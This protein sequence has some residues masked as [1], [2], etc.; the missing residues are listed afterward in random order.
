MPSGQ[1]NPS[2]GQ[3]QNLSDDFDCYKNREVTISG[4]KITGVLSS[5]DPT[6]F[7]NHIP[8]VH[9]FDSPFAQLFPYADT[10]N[11]G[12]VYIA[13]LCYVGPAGTTTLANP[14]NVDPSTCKYDQFKVDA[15][16]PDT[17]KPTCRLVTIANGP[18][19]VL[20]V[21]VQDGP[22]GLLSVEYTSTN[23]TVTW[24]ANLVVGQTSPT[25][26]MRRRSIRRRE[27]P[28]PEGD[29]RLGQ[30]DDLR[31]GARRSRRAALA[32]GQ[33][34]AFVGVSGSQSG[35]SLKNL[36]G[37]AKTFVVTVNGHRIPRVTLSRG[38]ATTVSI[39]RWLHAKQ[40]NSVVVKA[41]GRGRSAAIIG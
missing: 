1:S 3:S 10:T 32:P 20:T 17:Q 19:K 30:R 5:S 26:S 9:Y 22:S 18:P 37:A 31:P 36:G 21:A 4:G 13:A 2:D 7:T 24:D 12:G 6:C 34:T 25:S 8:F 14:T 40:K 29:R 35:L 11:N 41:V 38:T 33:P 15:G 27:P 28:S 23:A 39:A 16:A